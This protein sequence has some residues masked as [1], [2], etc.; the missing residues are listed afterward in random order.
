MR[1]SPRPRK[2]LPEYI[3]PVL[4]SLQLSRHAEN[5]RLVILYS[6]NDDWHVSLGDQGE[7]IP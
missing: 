5:R 1:R 6:L 2:R 4:H 7:F 3:E